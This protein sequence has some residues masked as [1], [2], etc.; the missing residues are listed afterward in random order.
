MASFL[1]PYG[2]ALPTNSSYNCTPFLHS[3]LTKGKLKAVGFAG[4]ALESIHIG[5][6]IIRIGFL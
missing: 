6:L 4:R 1:L 5:A 2:S 3:L